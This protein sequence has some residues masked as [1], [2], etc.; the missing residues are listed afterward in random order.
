MN[1]RKKRSG[2]LAFGQLAGFRDILII[3]RARQVN[4]T[5]P[6]ID[7]TW[8]PQLECDKSIPVSKELP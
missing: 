3:N 2:N 5:V 7:Q 6:V 4:V 8:F 1:G